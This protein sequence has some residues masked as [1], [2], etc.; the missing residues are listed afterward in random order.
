VSDKITGRYNQNA[1]SPVQQAT[2]TAKPEPT[3]L[4]GLLHVTPLEK[5]LYDKWYAARL[6]PRA[7]KHKSHSYEIAVI[8]SGVASALIARCSCGEEYDFTDY[9]SW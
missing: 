6:K 3:L 8:P 5:R 1:A 7:R 2:V 9:E 4:G